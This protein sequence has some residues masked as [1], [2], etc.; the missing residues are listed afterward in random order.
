MLW[1]LC[2]SVQWLLNGKKATTHWLGDSDFTSR[3]PQVKWDLNPIYLEQD[4]LITSAGTAAPWIVA[5]L[6]SVNYMV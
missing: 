6:L 2:V 4:R 1:R 3:F 5:F